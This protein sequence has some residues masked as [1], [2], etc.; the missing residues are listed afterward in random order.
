MNFKSLLFFVNLP[1][2]SGYG[3]VPR[4]GGGGGGV[5]VNGDGPQRDSVNQGEGYGAGG[6]PHGVSG[7][8]HYDGLPGV[9]LM[10]V[11]EH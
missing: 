10:E 5:L 1:Y 4:Y 9:I 3:A 7:V 11:E 8:M 2:Y 6:G